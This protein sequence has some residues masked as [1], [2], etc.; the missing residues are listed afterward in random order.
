MITFCV[1]P[2]RRPLLHSHEP[3][4]GFSRALRAW[5]G[6]FRDEKLSSTPRLPRH[7]AFARDPP[8]HHVELRLAHLYVELLLVGPA[9]ICRKV[10]HVDAGISDAKGRKDRPGL[11][12]MLKAVARREVDLV[13]VGRLGALLVDLL[14]KLQERP[15]SVDL[16]LHQ[17]GLDTSTPGGRAG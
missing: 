5:H 6:G 3:L 15:K 1:C 9:L 17:Q 7:D 11:D 10:A 16:H 14:A 13:S 4:A 2:K 8:F 12:A